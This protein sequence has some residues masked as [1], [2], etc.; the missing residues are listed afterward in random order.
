MKMDNSLYII[1]A[2]TYGEVILELAEDCNFQVK[3]FFDDNSDLINTKVQGIEVLGG[4]SELFDKDFIR[5][6][7]FITSIGNN[8]IRTS[9]NEK[10]IKMGGSTPRL[11]HPNAHVSRYAIINDGAIIHSSAFIYTASIIDRSCI[12]SPNSGISHHTHLN[13]GVFVSFGATV[14]AYIEVKQNAFIGMASNVSTNVKY[15]GE[16]SLVGAGAVV[17][18]DVPN[19][20]VV[21]GNPARYLRENL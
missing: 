16:N 6:K 1:G 20:A 14:G 2:G 7:N 21:V 5:G 9:I 10:I 12:I 8:K 18:K 3:G 4:I 15:V 11:I 17:L 13:P 19:N